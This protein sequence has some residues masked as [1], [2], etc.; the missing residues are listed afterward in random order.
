MF[1]CYYYFMIPQTFIFFGKSGCGKGTQA[2]LLI[3][4]LS[5][6]DP[7]NKIVYVETGANL[8]EF[9]QEIGLSAELTAKVMAEGGLLP[10]FIPIWIWTDQFVRKVA[11][12]EHLVLDGLSRQPYEAP[13][14]DDAL[15]FYK[16]Q[17][18]F[19]IVMNVSDDWARERLLG[20]ARGD[21]NKI[22]I[23][24]RLD[25]FGKNVVPTIDYFRQSAYY[26][27]LDINGEQAIPAVFEELK[28]KAGI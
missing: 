19:V 14:L 27:V 28:R 8:R 15:K 2:K 13:I 6:K 5:K 3:E 4:Y 16:R 12:H 11:G 22:D 23:E 21:D 7:E 24:N 17:K 25:W 20:R 10:S 9:S 26:T 1:L 18:P